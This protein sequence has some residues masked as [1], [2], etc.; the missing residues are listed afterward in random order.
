MRPLQKQPYDHVLRQQ[1][2]SDDAVRGM[3]HYILQ[4]PVRADLAPQAED[5]PFLGAMVTGYPTLHPLDGGFWELFWRLRTKL[6][7]Q[8]RGGDGEGKGVA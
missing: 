6:T 5:W 1:E 2:R 8:H 7:D 4:N 3:A